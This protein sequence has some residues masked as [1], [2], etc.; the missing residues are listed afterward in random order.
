MF[1]EVEVSETLCSWLNPFK[2]GY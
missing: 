1:L 2:T